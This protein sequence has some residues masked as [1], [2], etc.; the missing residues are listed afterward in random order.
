LGTLLLVV[1]GALALYLGYKFVA[2]IIRMVLF[3]AIIGSGIWVY[4]NFFK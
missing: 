3:L 4:M 1:A 2:G